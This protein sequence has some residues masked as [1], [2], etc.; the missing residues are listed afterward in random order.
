MLLL[1]I[2]FNGRVAAQDFLVNSLSF[3]LPV[4]DSYVRTV[5]E[6]DRS[7]N[8]QLVVQLDANPQIAQRFDVFTFDN[9]TLGLVYERDYVRNVE[10]ESTCIQSAGYQHIA[11]NQM[12]YD[13]TIGAGEKKYISR[14]RRLYFIDNS[15]LPCNGTRFD[16]ISPWVSV[17]QMIHLDKKFYYLKIAGTRLPH[18]SNGSDSPGACGGGH[19]DFRGCPE[20]Q[21]A[22]EE[23]QA[24]AANPL[25][26]T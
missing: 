7:G 4:R 5:V 15:D 6:N 22:A 2:A 19:L 1:L 14:S 20:N 10:I 17:V 11:V 21:E 12:R 24:E 18:C 16:S 9:E 8:A 25:P 3:Q 23:E 26:N 13:D